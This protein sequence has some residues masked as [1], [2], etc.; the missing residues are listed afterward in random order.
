MPMLQSGRMRALATTWDARSP[1][2]QNVPTF[3]ESGLVRL[4]QREWFGAFLPRGVIA[5]TVDFAT[6]EMTAALR[7]AG[8]R[9]AL[10]KSALQQEGSTAQQLQS[11][12]RTEHA[13]WGPVV[14]ASGFAPEA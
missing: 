13:F 1:F 6:A 10:Q 8:V 14:K 9:D 5:T 4:T 3:K 12:L 2:L 11:A 7:A